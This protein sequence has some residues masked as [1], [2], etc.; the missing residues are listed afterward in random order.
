M[1]TKK[2]VI[3]AVEGYAVAG[4]MEL[5]LWCDLRVMEETAILGVFC[6]RFGLFDISLMSNPAFCSWPISITLIVGVPLIDGGT[7]RLPQLIGLSRALDLILTG[8][9][10]KAKE[11]LEIGLV[12]RICE[13]GTGECSTK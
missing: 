1:M 8:R 6:R 4:G 10:V 13:S 3:A 12:N 2:P 5:A 7:A 9:E 11:A